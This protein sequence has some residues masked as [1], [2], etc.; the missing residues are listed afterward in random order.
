[1]KI[2]FYGAAQCVTGS[3]F[4]IE[5]G[6]RKLMVDCG[7]R[8]GKD[9]DSPLGEGEFPFAPEKVDYVFLTHA[10]IDHSGLLPLLVKKGFGGRILTTRATE[11]LC[12]I[13]LPDSGYIQEMEV[14]WKNRK[15][16]RA[17]LPPIE[18]LYTVQDARETMKY[19]TP[20][21]YGSIIS[22]CD[23]VQVRFTDAGHLLGSASVELWI[24]EAEKTTKLVFSGDIGNLNKPIIKDPTYIEKA[25][26]VVMET[27][28]GGKLHGNLANSQQRLCEIIADTFARGGNLVIPSFAVGRT[29]ELIYEI[30]EIVKKNLLPQIG[31]IPVYVDSPLG[32]EA[33][34]I[35]S[36]NKMA[37][38]DDDILARIKNGDNPFE[39]DT[40]HYIRTAE[41]S[42]EINFLEGSKIIISAS[43]MCEAGRIKHHLK[44]NL[45]RVDS[46][47]MFSGYQAVGTLG[48]K[49]L[50]GATKVKIF[51]EEININAK[52]ERLE[53]FFQPCGPKWLAK[54]AACFCTKTRGCI[55]GTWRAGEYAG[56]R[57]HYFAGRLSYLQTQSLQPV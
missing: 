54:L 50:D 24:T 57:G 23:G 1:M 47:V 37:Y 32:V 17:G 31:S 46:T 9:S 6:N 27:T 5:A 52:I 22:V 4:M 48:R 12:S 40:L 39:F 16:Q 10:H 11:Q 20:V 18:P 49:I 56:V 55:P 21:E 25:D 36:Q 30:S 42:K 19:F 26:Y 45:W 8:Q 13:M 35:Y 7:M 14:E 53:G 33:T 44:H 3:C 2:N 28:Y 43:G 34:A 15:K 41:E 38:Y 29:Q 51:G